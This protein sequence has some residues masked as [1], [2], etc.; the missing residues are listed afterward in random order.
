MAF[1]YSELSAN[2]KKIARASYLAGWLE[3]HEG[4]VLEESELHSNCCDTDEDVLYRENGELI[5][6]CEI[7]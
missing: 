6:D 3:T 4:E 1:K 2:A 7:Y 5:E